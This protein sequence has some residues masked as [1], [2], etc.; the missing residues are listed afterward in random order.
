MIIAAEA[1]ID[2]ASKSTGGI[3]MNPLATVFEVPTSWRLCTI[4]MLVTQVIGMRI[5]FGT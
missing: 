2:L 1:A 4:C 3:H 5:P